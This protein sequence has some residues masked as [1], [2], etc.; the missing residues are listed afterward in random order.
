MNDSMTTDETLERLAKAV[1]MINVLDGR[2]EASGDRYVG[3]NIERLIIEQELAQIENDIYRDPGALAPY[4]TPR[5]PRTD[6]ETAP[7]G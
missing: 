1:R 4:L 6:N 5:R 2:R 7:A 3:S